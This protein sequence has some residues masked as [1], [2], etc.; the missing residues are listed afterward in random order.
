MST[1]L[2][3]YMKSANQHF[4]L[5]VEVIKRPNI[6]SILSRQYYSISLFFSSPLEARS[7]MGNQELKMPVVNSRFCDWAAI[8]TAFPHFW[9]FAYDFLD[10]RSIREYFSIQPMRTEKAKEVRCLKF[11]IFGGFCDQLLS[12][13]KDDRWWG[14]ATLKGRRKTRLLP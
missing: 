5:H 4:P 9:A 7:H 12:L 2:A 1:K 13:S 14:N 8:L 10:Q 3:D 6:L 11:S